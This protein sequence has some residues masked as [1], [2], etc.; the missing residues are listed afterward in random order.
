MRSR[1][2]HVAALVTFGLLLPGLLA[3]YLGLATIAGN[4]LR[5]RVDY[6]GSGEGAFPERRG[7]T[8][9]YLVG[10]ALALAVVVLI[11]RWRI[12]HRPGVRTTL[13]VVLMASAGFGAWLIT[14]V[15]AGKYPAALFPVDIH[16]SWWRPLTVAVGLLM[17]ALCGLAL[18]VL[19]VDR[20]V[21]HAPGAVRVGTVVLR[22]DD[23]DRAATFWTAA[24]GYT[25]RPDP[26][27]DGS[28]LLE[29]AGGCGPSL[30]LDTDDRTHLDLFVPDRAARDAEVD[31]LLSLGARRADPT[32]GADPADPVD[33]EHVVLAD[34]EGTLFCVVVRP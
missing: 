25:R 17:F 7:L 6:V 34:P 8:V 31:R 22:V 14:T 19:T 4:D 2:L 27:G 21:P 3:L 18:A 1:G 30:T 32:D 33:R 23:L 10:A 15:D 13:T 28:P 24:L 29:P 11:E 12:S 16:P 5:F 20:P 9:G 26:S